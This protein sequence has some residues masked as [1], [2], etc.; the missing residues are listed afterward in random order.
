MVCIGKDSGRDRGADWLQ[1]G[2]GKEQ[3]QRVEA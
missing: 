3:I 1:S 2:H